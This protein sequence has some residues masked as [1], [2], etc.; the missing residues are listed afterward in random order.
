[1]RRAARSS[2][3]PTSAIAP[4]TGAATLVVVPNGVEVSK[5]SLIAA[6][7]IPIT[8]GRCQG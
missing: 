5:P 1:L 6:Y 3:Q 2:A 4:T 7:P 8:I